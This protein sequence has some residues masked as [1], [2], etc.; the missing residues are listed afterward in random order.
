[1]LE[2]AIKPAIQEKVNRR[3]PRRCSLGSL[4][5]LV[6]PPTRHA[7]RGRGSLDEPS[8]S[9]GYVSKASDT[10]GD[11]SY[12][13]KSPSAP[14]SATANFEYLA[15]QI[16]AKKFV[17]DWRKSQAIA[18]CGRSKQLRNSLA[19]FAGDQIRSD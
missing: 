12:R 16:S 19:T 5:T 15:C 9:S 3:L 7:I 2:K 8:R 13:R 17:S 14:A 11:F 10:L 18:K 6:W 4:H 1:M